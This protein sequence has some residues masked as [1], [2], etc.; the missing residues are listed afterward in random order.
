MGLIDGNNCWSRAH[1]PLKVSLVHIVNYM[2]LPPL[3]F[4]PC[5]LFCRL[6][7]RLAQHLPNNFWSMETSSPLNLHTELNYNQLSAWWYSRPHLYERAASRISAVLTQLVAC[8]IIKA[9]YNY[10]SGFWSRRGRFHILL[11]PMNFTW[12]AGYGDKA[13][14]LIII[15]HFVNEKYLRAKF[16]FL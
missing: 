2:A 11:T 6:H 4:K 15:M 9:V 3:D 1:T 14:T 12:N 8:K 16:V 5:L 13:S 10:V 7:W